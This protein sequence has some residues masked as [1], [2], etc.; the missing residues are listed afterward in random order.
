[1]ASNDARFTMRSLT[2]GN[3]AACQG[4]MTMVSP[5]R[6]ARMCNWQV[7]APF[8][9]PWA[10]PSIMTPHVPQ[11]PSR[12]SLSNVMGSPP[13]STSRLLTTS[14]ISRNDM[15]GLMSTAS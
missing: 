10:C 13:A 14:S 2:M 3:P 5:S 1:M 15:S 4:S 9:G 11:M 8:Q 12:Q 7:A 6:N